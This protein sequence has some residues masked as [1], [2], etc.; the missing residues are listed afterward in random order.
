MG[1]ALG[2]ALGGSVGV[3]ACCTWLIV[4]A[5]AVAPASAQ[6]ENGDGDPPVL[7]TADELTFDQDT[8]TATAK[9]NV[10]ISQGERVLRADFVTFNESTGLVTANGNV[11][12]MEPTGEVI[13]A[14]Y[15]ELT[16]AMKEGFVRGLR[17]LLEEDARLAAVSGQRRGGVETQLNRAVYSPCRQCLEHRP[18][19][20]LWQIKA[21]RVTHNQETHDIV[22][23][24]ARLEILG[25]PVAYTPYLSHPDPSV[26]RRTGF[27][28]PTYGSSN[29]LG[30]TLQLPFFWAI[31]PDRDLTLDPIVTSDEGF[32]ASGE[33]RQRFG[34]GEL[35]GRASATADAQP[36]GSGDS[37][38]HVDV[39]TR[40]D[41]TDIWRAGA[42]IN[43]A[44]DD[45]YLQ[46]YG[47]TS[48]DTLLT[49]GFAE[50][51]A[52][53]NYARVEGLYTQDLRAGIDQDKV[54]IVV[55]KLDY[56]AVGQPSRIGA[57]WTADA[58]FQAVSRPQG[59]AS[60][61]LSLI[62]GWQ[63]PRI[64]PFGGVY[65][66]NTTVQA[67]L[68]NVSNRADD[69]TSDFE[70]VTGR[71]FPQA[72][73]EI[74]YPFVRTAGNTQQLIE[75]VGAIVASPDNANSD[76]IPNEDSLVFEF[77]ETNLLV[78]D[79][80]P[81]RDRVSD[82]QHVA[83]GLRAGVFGLS[84]GST[85]AF[86]GQSYEFRTGDTFANG[87]GLE[88]NL[89][90]IVGRVTVSPGQFLD[91][92]YKTRLDKDRLDFNRNEVQLST[93]V[94]VLRLAADYVF[95]DRTD[96]FDQREEITIGL[97]S[98]VTDQWTISGQTRQ[99]LTED[100]GSLS[101]NV[102]INYNCDCLLLTIDL[103]RS[104]TRDRDIPPTDSVFVRVTFKTLGEL[105]G[106][107]F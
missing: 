98:Q 39:S 56:A 80:L 55:P 16:D 15:A 46:R 61:R 47:F 8:G 88:D 90:D 4:V 29:D 73:L 14:E 100:G 106:Q 77:D 70:G 19:T 66:L 34:A 60:Q 20:P 83:Y 105:R 65:T 21:R 81:G 23:R 49:Q 84:G 50:G 38:G 32:V 101:H 36:D 91:I 52:G 6:Q 12:L 102:S 93:G 86:V 43:L 1:R 87:S 94:P 9:G 31:K 68:Y 63:L 72:T 3:A 96:D 59:T 107:V 76:D 30:F 33:Y 75:P 79:R 28:T 13:F 18:N 5:L 11:V 37:R 42:D 85:T 35:R 92:R 58:N 82:G 54:P 41:L 44:S 69:P 22:Y 104:F 51:F 97:T 74:R 71:I 53:R 48:A 78:A 40:F 10:E 45:T 7:V 103:R 67:D 64:G 27:L 24:D 57:R 26:D 62:G 99:D 2:R 25:V 95:F 17:M 89:S